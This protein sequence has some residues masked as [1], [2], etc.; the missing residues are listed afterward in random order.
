MYLKVEA[1]KLKK[2]SPMLQLCMYFGVLLALFLVVGD[3]SAGEKGQ[4][5]GKVAY[6]ISKNLANVGKLIVGASYVAGVGFAMMGLLKLKAHKDNPTQ[7]PLSQPIVLL[8]IAAALVWL[9]SLISTGG[10]TIWG[11]AHSGQKG[12]SMGGSM[13]GLK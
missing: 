7:T 13:K 5:I 12:T 1:K 11:D 10:S 4:A 2:W 6:N 8:V 9:P 3:A